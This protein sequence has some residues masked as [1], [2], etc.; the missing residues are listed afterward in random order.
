MSFFM[1]YYIFMTFSRTWYDSP[2]LLKQHS[3]LP[4]AQIYCWLQTIDKKLILV[5][6]DWKKWQFPWGKLKTWETKVQTIQ[7]EIYEETWLNIKE[8]IWWLN[9]FWY[10]IIEEWDTVYLQLRYKL[11]L[12]TISKKLR[13]FQH[14]NVEDMDKITTAQFVDIDNI[15]KTIPWLVWS[16]ELNSFTHS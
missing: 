5:S 8:D 4:I 9:M 15:Q 7:R 16:K 10:Y 13:L 6:K 11:L 1:N 12:N 2:S 14:E 3:S